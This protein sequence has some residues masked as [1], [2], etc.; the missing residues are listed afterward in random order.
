MPTDAE[1][2]LRVALGKLKLDKERIDRQIGALEGI[3]KPTAE[4]AGGTRTRKARMTSATR[5]AISR[6]LK[7][8][9]A[10]RK[11]GKFKTS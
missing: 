7:A 4:R 11:A 8:H 2:I 9:W 6:K 3:L 5:K 1:K 10:K